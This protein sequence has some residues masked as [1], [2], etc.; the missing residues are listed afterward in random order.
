MTRLERRLM[1]TLDPELGNESSLKAL[2][3]DQ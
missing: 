1:R 3:E 2:I